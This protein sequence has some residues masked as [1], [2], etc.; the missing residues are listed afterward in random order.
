MFMELFPP[1][2]ENQIPGEIFQGKP[3]YQ[4]VPEMNDSF[5]ISSGKEKCLVTGG[6]TGLLYARDL[7][8]ELQAKHGGIPCAEYSDS[9]DLKFRCYHIDLKKGSGGVEDIKRTLIRLRQLR[10]NAALIEYENRICLDSLPGTAAPDAFT[11]EQIREIVSCAEEN[12]IQVIP[13][14]Q[15]FGHLEYL[16]K[17]P[18]Y[19]Q[20]S[21]LQENVSQLCPLN[22]AAFELWKKAFLEMRSL[23]PNSKYFH[24]GGDE[25]RNL[26]KCPRCAEFAEKHSREELFFHHIERVCRCVTG[27]GVRPI[28]WHDMLARTGRFDL[29]AKLPKETVLFYWEYESREELRG[30]I[31][32]DGNVFVSR[33]WIGKVHSINDFSRAPHQFSKYMEDAP[34]EIKTRIRELSDETGDLKS[35]PLH[36]SLLDTGLTVYGASALGY[37]P[38]GVL[39]LG[40]T[41]RL[42]S[43][44]QMWLEKETEGHVVTRWASSDSLDGARGPASLRDPQLMFAAELM[45]KKELSLDEIETRYDRSFGT[46]NGKIAEMMDLMVYSSEEN[47]FNWAE[48]LAPEF[49]ALESEIDPNLKPLFRKF[50]AAMDAE[51]LFRQIR[52]LIWNYPEKITGWEFSD[53]V[54]KQLPQIKQ[55][56]RDIFSDEFPPETL[57]EWLKRMF[58]PYEALYTGMDILR[59]RQK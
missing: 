45:W 14:L 12:G 26:G 2:T 33:K 49:A 50:C 56:L 31:A 13:L 37:P 30:R 19:R 52:S 18:A 46:K 20:Y 58:E 53:G 24:I 7:L 16:L 51:L 47:F 55:K 9:P 8:G 34:E 10:Y 28:L 42:W 3:E 5:R 44:M 39:L 11:H 29:L 59:N 4:L 23:H 21:E 48:H 41:K 43:N 40:D 38:R 32:F 15:S 22:D 1:N 35:L 57:E 6:K 25:T 54:R 36:A 27:E 17:L